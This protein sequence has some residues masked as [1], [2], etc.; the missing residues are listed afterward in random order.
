VKDVAE[1]AAELVVGGEAP[2][3]VLAALLDMLDGHKE[4]SKASHR[5]VKA[6][7]ASLSASASRISPATVAT[8]LAAADAHKGNGQVVAA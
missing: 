1:M 5:A 4:L 8:A 7:R 3:D 6:A 2:D